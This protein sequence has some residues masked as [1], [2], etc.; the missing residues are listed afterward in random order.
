MTGKEVVLGCQCGYFVM[1]GAPNAKILTEV[2]EVISEPSRARTVQSQ[3]MAKPPATGKEPTDR[4]ARRLL[5]VEVCAWWSTGT[6]D[7]QSAAA[8]CR[9][10]AE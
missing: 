6:K 2:S 1:F 3:R 5:A 8:K 9:F 10:V 7:M 4:C